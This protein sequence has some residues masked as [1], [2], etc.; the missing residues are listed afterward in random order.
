MNDF[1]QMGCELVSLD[2]VSRFINVSTELINE[3]LVRRWN[4]ITSMPMEE[5]I[6]VV[7]MIVNSTFF[8]FN[9]KIYKQVLGIPMGLPL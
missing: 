5:L 4:F 6:K 7:Q 1:F 2:V 8:T 9:N 3:S